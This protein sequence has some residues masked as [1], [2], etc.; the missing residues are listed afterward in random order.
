M[1]FPREAESKGGTFSSSFSRCSEQLPQAEQGKVR[2]VRIGLVLEYATLNGGEHSLLAT[3]S[4]LQSDESARTVP[5]QFAF[6]AP[7]TGPLAE[8]LRRRNWSH[9]PLSLRTDQ[10]SRIST[11][12]WQR[13]LLDFI[14]HQQVDLLHANSLT[15]GRLLGEVAHALPVPTTAH[16]RDIMK[17]SRAAIQHLNRHQRLIAVSHATRAFH[18]AQGL[19]PAQTITLYNG[20]DLNL[21]QPRAKT[22]WLKQALGLPAEALLAVTIGQI[23]LRKGQ[24]VLADAAVL[25]RDH[26]PQLHYLIIGQRH[27]TKQESQEYEEAI[28]QTFQAAGIGEWL[29]RWDSRSDIAAILNEAD[30]LIHPALQEPLG[31]VLLEAAASGTPIVAT[32]VGGTSEILT[33]QHSAWLVPAHDPEALADGMRTLAENSHLCRQFGKAAFE[34]VAQRFNIR[35]TAGRLVDTWEEVFNAHA[36]RRGSDS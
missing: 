26:L 13:Q 22:G 21:F 5:H 4:A 1:S 29:H 6:L 11:E 30:L 25:N 28:P 3:V 36:H 20:V 33:H 9:T 16:L 17:L 35:N 24:R 10:G 2:S 15:M 32:D 18:L 23:C 12:T 19:I 34:D 7:A 31:R 14:Q 27:S 8:E